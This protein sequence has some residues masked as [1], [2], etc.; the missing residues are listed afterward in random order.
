MT[1]FKLGVWNSQADLSDDEAAGLYFR[2]IDG[3]WTPPGF[4]AEVYAFYSRLTGC[5]PEIDLVPEN[6]LDSCPWACA[7]ELSGAHVIL[8][9]QPDQS[10]SML[11]LVLSLA[12][13]HGLVCFDPQSAKV[14]L[15]LRLKARRAVNG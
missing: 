10:E 15:P 5:Y 8:A 14:H 4:D 12:E 6:E 2:L 11:P 7:I 13:E 1:S 3:K 9:I